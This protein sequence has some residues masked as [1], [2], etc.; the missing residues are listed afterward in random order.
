MIIIYGYIN[1]HNSNCSQNQ[2]LDLVVRE[3]DTFLPFSITIGWS[4]RVRYRDFLE[5][6]VENKE[7]AD[8]ESEMIEIKSDGRKRSQTVSDLAA[9]QKPLQTSESLHESTGAV[10]DNILAMHPS[11]KTSIMLFASSVFISITVDRV[12][13]KNYEI[14]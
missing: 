5:G 13:D 2:Q 11:G 4:E 8:G 10:C 9:E 12:H 14:D 3:N 1:R 6:E 7:E